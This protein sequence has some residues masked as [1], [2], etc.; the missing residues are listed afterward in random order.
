MHQPFA[1]QSSGDL[2]P[3]SGGQRRFMDDNAAAGFRH[4]GKDALH[5]QGFQGGDV[6]DLGLDALAG[7]D[8]AGFQHFLQ[9]RAPADQR[10]VRPLQQ[11]EAAVERQ[12]AAVVHHLFRHRAVDA[13]GFQEDDRVGVANGG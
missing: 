1:R 2:G 11:D 8:I 4:R 9:H 10:N 12:G 3:E 13:L 5:I 6:D 7:Q